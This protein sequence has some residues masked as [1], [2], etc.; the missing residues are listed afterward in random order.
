MGNDSLARSQERHGCAY[1]GGEGFREFVLEFV[2]TKCFAAV[3]GE[4]REMAMCFIAG[5]MRRCRQGFPW[6]RDFAFSKLSKYVGVRQSCRR[7]RDAS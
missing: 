4:V 6:T 1:V 2:Q 5:C 7:N 3:D